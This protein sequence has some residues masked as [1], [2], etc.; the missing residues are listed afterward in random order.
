MKQRCSSVLAVLV[1]C[2]LFAGCT[3]S[4]PDSP[5]I[6]TLLNSIDLISMDEESLVANGFSYKEDEYV[7]T[8]DKTASTE[9]DEETLISV[10]PGTFITYHWFFNNDLISSKYQLEELVDLYTKKFGSPECEYNGN[11]VRASDSLID[12][13]YESKETF[14]LD[15]SYTYTMDKRRLLIKIST[16]VFPGTGG[17][18][19]ASIAVSAIFQG[20]L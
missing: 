15:Y 16:H 8:Y 19:S 14:F 10:S 12:E 3:S 17:Y 6:S 11:S 20:T 18:S 2:M 13:A 5:K 1:C 9:F 4:T 7:S